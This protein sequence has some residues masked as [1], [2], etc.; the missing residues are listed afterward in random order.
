MDRPQSVA[1][2]PAR[3]R[4]L[5]SLPRA[6]LDLLIETHPTRRFL[7]RPMAAA[8]GLYLALAVT[9]ASFVVNN[10][11]LSYYKFLR[12][13]LGAKVDATYSRGFGSALLDIPFYAAARAA[14]AV[15]GWESAFGAPLTHVGIAFATIVALVVTLYL[16][17]RIL[18]VLELPAGPAVL[19]LALLGTPLL[20]YTAFEPTY[21]HGIDAFG[22]TLATFLLLRATE[23]PAGRVLVGLGATLA[24][25]VSVRP[26]NVAIV[27]AMLLPFLLRRQFRTAGT[28]FAVA[29]AVG[30]L[31]FALPRARKIPANGPQP[32]RGALVQAPPRGIEGSEP[33]AAGLLGLYWGLCKDPGYHLSFEQCLLNG[34]GLRWNPDA[35]PKMLFSV[36]RGLFLWTPL[37][38]LASAG[39]GLAFLSRRRHRPFLLGLS[40]S[41]LFL[42]LVHMVW[43]DFWTGGFSFSQRFL[44]S[45]LPFY[46]V[47][48]AE[49]LR[50]WR[51]PA[52][53]V[54]TLCAAFSLYV[55]FAQFMGYK[56]ISERD[57]LDTILGKYD[58]GERT[59]IDLARK[60]GHR[61]LE[62][63]GLR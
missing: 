2:P 15:T 18:V 7:S 11:A 9:F 47:G 51:A 6:A 33:K 59:P 40:A 43:G 62:R 10:D 55:G 35:P 22:F 5:A 31:L 21:K 32:E 63:Y 61:A 49:L 20:Y 45:L 28:V 38:A 4:A 37:T 58:G 36:R 16:G 19:L 24:F 23:Q 34:F 52:F 56:G 54:L 50:R 60:V 29:L 30:V 17:W 41:A 27:P 13:F 53:A 44:A 12:R 46:L 26:A 48:T 39:V 1:A 8:I 25:L 14:E 57:G 42:L 3:A